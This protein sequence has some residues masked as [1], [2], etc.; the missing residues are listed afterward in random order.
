MEP[1]PRHAKPVPI[2]SDKSEPVRNVAVKSGNTA[3]PTGVA[4]DTKRH[5]NTIDSRDIFDARVRRM[6]MRPLEASLE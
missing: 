5:A 4:A 1:G 3:P 2:R 6:P